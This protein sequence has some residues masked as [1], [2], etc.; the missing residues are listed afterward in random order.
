ML[1]LIP[2][3]SLRNRYAVSVTTDSSRSR[4]MRLDALAGLAAMSKLV[5]R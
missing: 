5:N 3:A 4:V 1:S 2:V